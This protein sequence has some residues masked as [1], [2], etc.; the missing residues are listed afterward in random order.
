MSLSSFDGNMGRMYAES[1]SHTLGLQGMQVPQP[2][3][4][5]SGIQTLAPRMESQRLI[6]YANPPHT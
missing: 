4:G 3:L 1:A 6:H 2:N 5:P